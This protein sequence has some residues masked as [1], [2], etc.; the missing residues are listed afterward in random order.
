MPHA[1]SLSSNSDL[2]SDFSIAAQ[3]AIM[4]LMKPSRAHAH[5]LLTSCVLPAGHCTLQLA[6]D[7]VSLAASKEQM[8]V[9][10]FVLK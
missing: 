9:Q 10:N 2:V 1:D 8:D 3:E 7:M 4:A 5:K 6:Y